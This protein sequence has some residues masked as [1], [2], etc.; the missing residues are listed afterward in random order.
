MD[1]NSL[2]TYLLLVSP[3]SGAIYYFL[4]AVE[5]KRNISIFPYFWRKQFI[6]Q[7]KDASDVTYDLFERRLVKNGI[8]E[9]MVTYLIGMFLLFLI[10]SEATCV[11]FTFKVVFYLFTINYYSISYITDL[12]ILFLLIF[13]PFI[14]KIKISN[15][16]TLR[17]S[18]SRRNIN[19]Q[20]QIKLYRYI[21]NFWFVSLSAAF[22]LSFQALMIETTPYYS[23]QTNPFIA[24]L[25]LEIFVIFVMFILLFDRI[26][27]A[28]MYDTESNFLMGMV[29]L[30]EIQ[31]TLL[32]KTNKNGIFSEKPEI[33]NIVSIGRRL[34]IIYE[35]ESRQFVS[36]IKWKDVSAFGLHNVKLSQG[37]EQ[38]PKE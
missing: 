27:I 33:C 20:R 8:K 29:K 2:S 16:D 10:R 23:Y 28:W 7:L 32:L 6:E 17:I 37:F 24:F 13:L 12:L 3:I 15:L 36:Q 1:L 21:K 9:F 26:R 31:K 4:K 22:G 14:M 38:K 19:D 35:W 30:P 25:P 11:P 34:K 5:T 18:E